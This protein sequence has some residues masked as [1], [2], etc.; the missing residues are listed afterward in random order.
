MTKNKAITLLSIISVIV[1]FVL[2][3]S[4]VRF[5]VGIKNYNSVIGA[6][7]LDYDLKEGTAYTLT[8]SEDNEEEVDDINKV[9][10]TLEYRLEE[11]GYT[12]Y[13]IKALKSTDST[14]KDYDIR[15]ATRT[16]DSLATD[17]SV[18]AAH[19]EVK[20][21]GGTSPNPTTEI[22][23]DVVVIADS[24]YLGTQS[25]GEETSYPVSISFTEEGYNGLIELIDGVEDGSSYYIEIKLGDKV[26]LSGS[27]A[28]TKDYFNDKSLT[29]YPTDEAS[30]K[31][32]A[33]QMRT[34]G[35]K[36]LYEIED[37]VTISSTYGA[38]VDTRALIVVCALA[39]ITMV[40]LVVLYKGLGVIGALS[41]LLFV[42]IETLMLIA[43]PNVVLSIGGVIGIVMAT[44]LTAV[45]VAY[46]MNSIKVEFA[47]SE[48][49][50][51]AA[52]KKGFKDTFMP[53]IGAGVVSGVFALAL[54]LLTSGITKGFAITFGIGTV[55]GLLTT[56]LFTRMYTALIL[57]LFENKEKFLNL[58]RE[59]A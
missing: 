33:L 30:A 59:E 41:M 1:A 18:V 21:F 51:V 37:P 49:T 5:S 7:E 56:L 2:A 8:L 24:Q 26:L 15:I 32:M 3:M 29:V 9:I 38:N 42:L 28:I 31:Q 55:V 45:G 43:V 54:L 36:Y 11:L 58:K 53:I 4:F 22:L 14:V 13:S 39:I 17:I 52:I 40:A 25:N 34:G 48:K 16:T 12:H 10:D 6:I 46:I 23:E 44:M 47:N 27:Q 50:V 20:I 35:L 19:G 57:P